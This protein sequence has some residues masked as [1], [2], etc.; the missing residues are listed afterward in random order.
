VTKKSPKMHIDSILLLKSLLTGFVAGAAF[1]F[2]KLPIPAPGE[3]ASI[4]GILGIF[5]GM[6]VV[7][8][9]F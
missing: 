4:V 6:L 1:T 5:L 7:K 2:L 9:L 3:F 8:S